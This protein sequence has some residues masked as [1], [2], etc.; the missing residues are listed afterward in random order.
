MKISDNLINYI[1]DN[2]IQNDCSDCCDYLKLPINNDIE[3]ELD[4]WL[5]KV[6]NSQPSEFKVD[7]G[8]YKGVFPYNKFDNY[9]DLYIDCIL[10]DGREFKKV[11]SYIKYN[12]IEIKQ[13]KSL[14]LKEKFKHLF[15]KNKRKNKYI[16]SKIVGSMKTCFKRKGASYEDTI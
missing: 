4:E 15:N 2:S 13:K 11:N 8:K 16:T 1:I 14:T 3:Q 12:M 5:K 10:P 9:V 7:F 6:K